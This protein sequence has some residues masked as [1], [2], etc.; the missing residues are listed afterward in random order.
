MLIATGGGANSD[1]WLQI[2]A[3]V[4]G[5]PVTAL[6]GSEVGAAGTAYL[7]GKAVGMYGDDVR[8]LSKRKVFT[9]DMAKH[10]FYVKQYAKYKKIYSAVKEIY[11]N[12]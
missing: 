4:L 2:K 8:L 9:P 10:E 1:V 5:I 12:D 7:A 6:N 11:S 3:D